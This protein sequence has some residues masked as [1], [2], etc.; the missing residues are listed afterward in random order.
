MRRDPSAFPTLKSEEQC[1]SFQEEFEVQVSAQ[2]VEDVLNAS[3]NATARHCVEL[4]HE[5]CKFIFAILLSHI[6]APLS[7][8]IICDYIQTRNA[9]A[10]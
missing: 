3:F 1:I 5:K 6:I 9:Q 7:L 4:F 10:A 2:G 8:A